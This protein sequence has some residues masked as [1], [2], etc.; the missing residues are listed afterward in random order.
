MYNCFYT[1]VSEDRAVTYTLLLSIT[2]I[3]TLH[4]HYVRFAYYSTS[5]VGG[6]RHN[7]MTYVCRN[8]LYLH[9]YRL[10]YSI[11]DYKLTIKATN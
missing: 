11:W 8:T 10:P 1:F 9:A 2:F 6:V 3:A 7:G 4:L 5:R